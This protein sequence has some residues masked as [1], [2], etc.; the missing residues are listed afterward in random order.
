MPFIIGFEPAHDK[1]NKMA[2][3]PSEDSDKPGH[4]L[5]L[6]RVFAQWVAKEPSFLHADREDSDQTGRMP[7]LIWVFAGPFTILL[8]LSRAG[9]FSIAFRIIQNDLNDPKKCFFVISPSASA[10]NS[11]SL[12]RPLSQIHIFDEKAVLCVCDLDLGASFLFKC[13]SIPIS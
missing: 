11:H 10:L 9:S 8:V 7:R 4:P 6:I 12:F 13:I 1:T 2:C 5:S 3:A